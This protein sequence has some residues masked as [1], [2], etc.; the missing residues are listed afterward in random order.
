MTKTTVQFFSNKMCLNYKGVQFLIEGCLYL[1]QSG[2]G[3]EMLQKEHLEP[4]V[5][6][7]QFLKEF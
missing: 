7:F 3:C 1:K 2:I 4:F 6:I 5:A